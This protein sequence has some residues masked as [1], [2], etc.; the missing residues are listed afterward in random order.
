MDDVE[1]I[2][3]DYLWRV[4]CFLQV[5]SSIIYNV[6]RFFMYS[7]KLPYAK[8]FISLPVFYFFNI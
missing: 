8:M 4:C 3:L 6:Y 2:G 1:L 5:I 7:F